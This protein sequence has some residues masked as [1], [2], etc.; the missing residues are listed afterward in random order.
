M[1]RQLGCLKKYMTKLRNGDNR[2]LGN[3]KH[4]PPKDQENIRNE[5]IKISHC[6]L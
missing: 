3:E 4:R 5:P 1:K 2:K 6:F